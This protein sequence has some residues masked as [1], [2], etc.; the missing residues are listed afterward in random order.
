MFLYITFLTVAVVL[1]AAEELND[2]LCPAWGSMY[3]AKDIR[4][5]DDLLVL[6]DFMLLEENEEE[7]E[8]KCKNTVPYAKCVVDYGLKFCQKV[9]DN[10]HYQ[11]FKYD[12]AALSRVCNKNDEA[13]RWYM[14]NVK[15]LNKQKV[16]IHTKCEKTPRTYGL[17][18]L[19]KEVCEID[20]RRVE[21][22]FEEI[23]KNC[24]NEALK[25][26]KLIMLSYTKPVEKACSKFEL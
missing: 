24:G 5:V 12:Y 1:S 10:I 4:S 14:D 13:R 20:K 6:N 7:L 23:S 26:V 15:C 16:S 11:G 18:D 8:K 22:T 2:D 19:T 9:S 17:K 3:C 25:L 21:C